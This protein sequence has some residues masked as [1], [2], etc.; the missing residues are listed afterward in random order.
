[1]SGSKTII[2]DGEGRLDNVHPGD[3]L[4]EDF[5]IGSDISLDE[6]AEGTGVDRNLLCRILAARASID[7][8]TGLRLSR[9]LR[10]SEGFFV[11]LQLDYDVEEAKRALNGA[12]EHIV[13]RAA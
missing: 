5:L 13:P 6:V 11:G 10:M 8:D 12:L 1:M 9:Y 4:R 3:I 7:V 2:A